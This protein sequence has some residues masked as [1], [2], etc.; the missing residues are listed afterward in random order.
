MQRTGHIPVTI[1]VAI[2]VAARAA[3]RV[4]TRAGIRVG[5]HVA[6][7]SA[8]RVSIRFATR[9]ATFV[10]T[11]IADR[12]PTGIATRVPTRVALLVVLVAGASCAGDAP[13]RHVAGTGRRIVSL[14]PNLTEILFALDLDEQVVGVT[15]YCDHPPEAAT[16]QSIGGF[17]NPNLEAILALEPDLAVATPNIG[18]RDAVLKLQSLGVEFLILE[19]PDFEGLW[20]TVRTLAESAGVPERGDALVSRLSAEVDA[21]RQQ[22]AAG[23]PVRALLVFAHDPLIVAGPGTFFDE[24]LTAAGGSNL[25]AGARARFPHFSLEQLVSDGPDVIIETVM[26]SDGVPDV[27]FWERWSTIPAVRDGRICTPPADVILRPG[28]RTPEG[29]RLL[30]DCLHLR[31]KGS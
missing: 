24:M 17:V 3:I 10:G 20:S 11:R 1:L 15:D 8:I 5:T 13:Q 30:A 4:A 28:P 26:T 14:A 25:A 29:L 22:H 9:I 12:V 2:R 23:P 7:R 21:V 18:N 19:T 16:K 6:I 31:A 27:A